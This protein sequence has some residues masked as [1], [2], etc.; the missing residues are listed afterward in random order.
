MSRTIGFSCLNLNSGHFRRLS[1]STDAQADHRLRCSHDISRFSQ[2]VAQFR[3]FDIDASLETGPAFFQLH[4]LHL[5]YLPRGA[6]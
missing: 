1:Y 2:D 6:H 4:T 3:L 5:L